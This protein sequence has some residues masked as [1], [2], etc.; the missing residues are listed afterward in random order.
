MYSS[1]DVRCNGFS[2]TDQNTLFINSRNAFYY[3][4][5]NTIL[6]RFLFTKDIL[7]GVYDFILFFF[8]IL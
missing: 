5:F 4:N 8:T 3:H 6:M 7:G 2:T 1:N